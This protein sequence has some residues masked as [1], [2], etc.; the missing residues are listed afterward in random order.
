[1]VEF[2][3]TL[4]HSGSHVGGYAN[5]GWDLVCNTGGGLAAGAFLRRSR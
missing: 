1:M 3:S 4:A 2:L 5:T